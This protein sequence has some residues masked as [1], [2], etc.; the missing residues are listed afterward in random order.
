MR[1]HTLDLQAIGPYATRQRIDFARLAGSGLFLLE[2]P[3]GAGKTTILDAITFALYGGL[4]GNGSGGD[5]L[6][7]HFAPPDAEPSVTL[8]FA[9]GGVRYRVRRSPEYRRPKRRG[10]GYT[11]QAAQVHLERHGGGGWTSLSANKAEAG[12]II[13]DQI[14]LNRDQ[15]TQVMLLPQGE[16]AKFLRS[17]DDDRR[18]LLTKLF[19][20]QLY[21][22]ITAELERGKQEATRAR[23]EA[24]ER[25]ATCA[26]AAAEAA[27]L[28]SE[29]R[30]ELLAAARTDRATRLKEVVA[31]LARTIEV[32]RAGLE[33]AVTQLTAAQQADASARRQAELMTRLTEAL[34]RLAAHESTRPA[35]QQL[36]A[37]LAAARQAEPVRPLLAALDDAE[38]ATR[39][40]RTA[41][42][43]VVAVLDEDLD[44]WPGGPDGA[45]FRARLARLTADSGGAGHDGEPAS[46]A[47][48]GGAGQEGGG[49]VS[50]AERAGGPVAGGRAA[51]GAGGAA[52]AYAQAAAAQAEDAERLAASLEHLVMAEAAVPG[53]E[54]ALAEL[55]AAAADAAAL[56][57]ALE[58]AKVELP[59]QITAVQERL[60]G[61]R[62]AAAGLAAAREQQASAEARLAAAV[63][64]AALVGELTGLDTALREA[65]D[66][67]QSAV[68]AYQC[69][70]EERLDNMAAELA[71][72]LAEGGA[73]PVCGSTD[74]PGP[75]AHLDNAVSAEDV[76]EAARQRDAAAQARDQ[77][78]D[79]RDAVAAQASQA[80]AAAGGATVGSLEAAVAE[81]D[82]QVRLAEQAATDAADLDRELAELCAGRDKLAEDL[83]NA[84]AAVAA[85]QQKAGDAAVELD[86]LAA[87]LRS[88][89][90][91]FGSVAAR[92][93]ALREAAVAGRALAQALGALAD[94]IAAEDAARRRAA[95]ELRA[96]G[97]A[98]LE[99]ARAAVL[100]PAEQADLTGQ[101]EAWATALA[102][103]AAATAAD[104]L[105]GLDPGR[106]AEVRET[107]RAAAGALAAAQDA[108][109]LARDSYQALTARDERLSERMTEL[110]QA[111][112]AADHTDEETGTVIRLA[113]LARGMDG[114]RRI[115][116]TTYVL[117]R[118]FEQVVQAANV[119]LAAMSAGRYEL[120]RTEEGE[121]RRQRTGLT[122]AVID[123]HTGEERSPKSLSGGETFYTSL[124]LALGLADVVR[125]RAG[126]VELDTLFIDEGF[127][128][129]DAQTLDQVMAVIDDLR[130]R[131][132]AVG[133]VSHVADLKDR[134]YERLEVRRLP[135]G[136]SA[137]TVVA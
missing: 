52:A 133:I 66:R 36:V 56:V 109:R 134:V 40:A 41:L 64:A 92:Q 51:G 14:G 101:A 85:A 33:I 79:E 94:A 100:P 122:L 24:R 113:G 84:V 75:A 87:E 115:A 96:S 82:G 132:R 111:E 35:H 80:S 73:C 10:D 7:S 50:G 26:A 103:L 62:V 70:M 117:R 15:F 91:E 119:R 30:G 89:A 37:R 93:R 129:L 58:A 47:E 72:R 9:I 137:A 23:Q 124:A 20:T 49:S 53:R 120:A 74:H 126:G 125:A 21:D 42:A 128:S 116:L 136:S 19:G 60:D 110:G 102:G 78:Q 46:G 12:E 67:H 32:T 25:I 95:R 81:L 1:L 105:A 18:A 127:G 71:D 114:H 38:D 16:F 112:E 8:D 104:D 63:R 17:D 34:A 31:E 3:T 5:R 54:A 130:D 44:D 55:G 76:D 22:L 121:S 4:S 88:A 108:E 39:A 61:A 6:H 131:G 99:A 29:A 57:T 123:R 69:A 107:A 106:A 48:V 77:A 97:L 2:G 83:V 135:D 86:R 45:D 65:I 118:W 68:D 28:D 27:G 11:T 90:A 98:S 59:G 43:E 13:T